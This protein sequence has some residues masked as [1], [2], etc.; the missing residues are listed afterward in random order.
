MDISIEQF[1]TISL[2][3][4]VGGLILYMFYIMYRLAK[5]SNAGKMGTIVIFG[6]LG[7]GVLGFVIKE[8]LT[9]VLDI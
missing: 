2:Y 9:V 4:C 5:D 7:F 6:T 3:V 1:E 8:I